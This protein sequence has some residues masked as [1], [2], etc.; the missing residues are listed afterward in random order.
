MS[1]IL[2]YSGHV[3]SNKHY[4]YLL[5]HLRTPLNFSTPYVK[6]VCLPVFLRNTNF[7]SFK[8]RYYQGGYAKPAL[9]DGSLPLKRFGIQAGSE[10][11]CSSLFRYYYKGSGSGGAEH[12]FCGER[13]SWGMN[14]EISVLVHSSASC[15][16]LT[17]HFLTLDTGDNNLC[18]L[19]GSIC[20]FYV[21]DRYYLTGITALIPDR[22]RGVCD[23]STMYIYSEGIVHNL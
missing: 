20:M 7:G 3:R 6:P 12:T 10:E 23:R 17:I 11:E 13:A 21:M 1:Y 19:H 18:H 5:F 8:W 22:K 14:H 16:S 9:A 2:P 4:H 15:S